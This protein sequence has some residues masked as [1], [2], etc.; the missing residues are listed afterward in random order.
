MILQH[1]ITYG[2]GA[3]HQKDE[4]Y[5]GIRR[6]DLNALSELPKDVTREPMPR[7][8]FLVAIVQNEDM[9]DMWVLDPSDRVAAMQTLLGYYREEEPWVLVNNDWNPARPLRVFSWSP[10]IAY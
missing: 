9:M 1:K 5:I 8:P 2:Q 4:T 7:H 6:F 10:E 3:W